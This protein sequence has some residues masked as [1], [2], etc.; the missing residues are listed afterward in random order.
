MDVII[1][2]KMETQMHTAGPICASRYIARN[3]ACIASAIYAMLLHRFGPVFCISVFVEKRN[4]EIDFTILEM[5]VLFVEA[6]WCSNCG[7]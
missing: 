7:C 6:T 5:R 3:A 1:P 2:F 4:Y